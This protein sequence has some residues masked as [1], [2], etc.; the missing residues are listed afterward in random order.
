ML[1]AGV[2]LAVLILGVHRAS[3]RNR[4]L[5]RADLER[6]RRFSESLRRDESLPFL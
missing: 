6:L 1:I 3:C 5:G 2:M 4:P